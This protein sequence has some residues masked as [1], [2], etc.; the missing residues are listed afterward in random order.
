MFPY[1]EPLLDRR[2]S[3][4]LTRVAILLII[5]LS[6]LTPP[7]LAQGPVSPT[8]APPSAA[9]IKEMAPTGTLRIAVYGL[10]ASFIVKDSKSGEYMGTFPELAKELAARLGVPYE[11]VPAN[12]IP[13]VSDLVK[14]GKADIGFDDTP[15][16]WA[17]AQGVKVPDLTPLEFTTSI[18]QT[19]ATVLVPPDSPVKTLADLKKPG[20]RILVIGA[21]V[22]ETFV[23][24]EYPQAKVVPVTPTTIYTD[25][26]AGKG[27]VVVNVIS[28]ELNFVAANPTY[29]I[30]NE[31]LNRDGA[32]VGISIPKGKAASLT[33]LNAFAEE[34]KESGWLQGVLTH[35]NVRGTAIPPSVA[36]V[37]ELA[38]TGK[39]RVSFYGLATAFL[40]KDAITG[41]FSG[42]WPQIAKE[43]AARL[44]VPYTLIGLE[45]AATLYDPLK[46]GEADV[47]LTDA[48][49]GFDDPRLVGV[50]FAQAF[51]HVPMTV[52]VKADSPYQTLADL[53]KP[54]TRITTISGAASD[55]LLQRDYKQA[56]IVR[57]TGATI[58]DAIKAGQA[59][60]AIAGMPGML[61]FVAANPGYRMLDEPFS[62]LEEG[63]AVAKGHPHALAYLQMFVEE[64]KASGYAQRL[65][66]Q[67]GGKGKILAAAAP[68][69]EL[70]PT[71]TMRIAVYGLWATFITKDAKT[72]EYTGV[73]P[74]LAKALAT[75]IGVP[76]EFVPA[77]TIP[78][79]SDV[80][81]SGKADIGFDDTPAF[82]VPAAGVNV[83]D[84]SP[85][86]FTASILQTP[87]MV[88]V[89]PD[90]PVKTLADLQTPGLRILVVAS[91]V[92]QTFVTREYKQAKVVPSAG[93][94]IYSDLLAGKG[95]VI[96]NQVSG[97]LNFVA[98]NPSYHIL[99][100]PLIRDGTIV[101]ISILK[102][103]AASLAYLNGFVEDLKTS[104]WLQQQLN[105][106]GVKGTN[107]P[108][109]A[110]ALKELAPTGRLRVALWIQNANYIT[111]DAKT[112][113]LTGVWAEVAKELAARLGIPY[114]VVEVNTIIAPN[115]AVKNNQADIGF[116]AIVRPA[117]GVDDPNANLVDVTTTYLQVPISVL[118]PAKSPIQTLADLNKPGVRISLVKDGSA[119]TIFT[120]DY[121]QAQL[122]RMTGATYFDPMKAG[123]AEAVAGPLSGLLEF[124]GSSADYRILKEN[125]LTN[126]SAISVLKGHPAALAYLKVFVEDI[127]A[128]GW[129][130]RTL[131]KY[132]KKGIV[133]PLPTQ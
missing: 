121:K 52:V 108:P 37:K 97:E 120:R 119:D 101:G 39:L 82:W 90:S 55:I 80:V 84:L 114:T 35:M 115:E 72:G 69:R 9:L 94:A 117:L 77:D 43:L 75:R 17:R 112:G 116:V 15:A 62:Q 57:A 70:A 85:L 126:E 122:L 133:I 67:S 21:G 68:V 131:D 86:D 30:L 4:K 96:V 46:K 79:V 8:Q 91:G 63:L 109:S 64:I 12:T 2:G 73:F 31:P 45:N 33:Y 95:D 59:D 54:G 107:I 25:L 49:F 74:E 89:P 99:S 102:G 104:G 124:M 71:G 123:Q 88:L 81:K 32:P 76:Y 36:A 65:I 105:R 78:G 98:S 38:P 44:G 3:L 118:V 128:S 53:R 1:Q 47:M 26:V 111:K 7:A 66:D 29:S 6:V 103:R 106:L 20:L 58:Y 34:I 129:V 5:A 13:G 61:S 110:A 23:A 11:F 19:P 60:A 125:L 132:G 27:D 113:E 92:A 56:Q 14:S 40:K 130:Q 16:Y 42:A 51:A 87:A 48:A 10:W 83:P 93:P 50:D 18:L 41:E 22:A 24:R 100:E 127:K 28:S